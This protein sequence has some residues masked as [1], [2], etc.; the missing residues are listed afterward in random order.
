VKSESI[1]RNFI[2]SRQGLFGLDFEFS[3]YSDPLR[4]IGEMCASIMDTDPRFTDEK[5]KICQELIHSYNTRVGER[6]SHDI[7]HWIAEALEKTSIQRPRQKKILTEKAH[8]IRTGK[9]NLVK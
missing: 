2:D 3:H 6:S 9:I 7:K 1:L 8:E 4:D 5:L